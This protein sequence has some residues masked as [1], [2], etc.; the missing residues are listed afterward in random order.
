MEKNSTIDAASKARRFLRAVHPE[1]KYI[2]VSRQD[3]DTKSWWNESLDPRDKDAI[4]S[5]VA[6]A[7]TLNIFVTPA[8]MDGTGG[9]E[10]ENVVGS[11]VAWVDIDPPK[12]R[13]DKDGNPLPQYKQELAEHLEWLEGTALPKLEELGAWVN[14]SGREGGR[15]AYVKLDRQVSADEVRALNKLL[16]SRYR[17]DK[18]WDPSR[19]LRLPG[20][21]NHKTSKRV[22]REAETKRFK[23]VPEELAEEL[24][25]DKPLSELVEESRSTPLADVGDMEPEPIKWSDY[26]ALRSRAVRKPNGLYEAD[27]SAVEEGEQDE[28]QVKKHS[29]IAGSVKECCRYGLSFAQ[30][31]WVLGNCKFAVAKV[32]ESGN[33]LSHY[34]AWA[35]RNPEAVA[36]REE[37]ETD[38]PGETDEPEEDGEDDEESAPDDDLSE[39][40]E[41][42]LRKIRVREE[43]KRRYKAESLTIDVPPI[44]P[45]DEFLSVED[46]PEEYLVQDFWPVSG[47]ALLAA[48][49]KAG[50]TTMMGNVVRALADGTPFLDK[51]HVRQPSGRV[52]LLDVELSERMARR[53]LRDQGI[54]NP[55]NAAIVSLRGRVSSFD[56]TDADTRAHWADALR[57]LG[58]SVVILDCLGPILS[59]MGIDENGT[60]VRRFLTAFNELLGES[61]ATEGMIVHHM[62]HEQERPRGTSVLRDW[63]DSEWKLVRS[64]DERSPRFLSAYG[65]DVDVRETELIYDHESRNLT[66]GVGSRG[67]AKRDAALADIVGFLRANPGS[68]GNAIETALQGSHAQRVI[69]DALKW[70]AEEGP[71][72]Y[73]RGASN[74]K[75]YSLT[76]GTD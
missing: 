49:Y 40:V 57:H 31:L 56:V 67:D 5:L 71:L 54:K 33:P 14:L 65:R 20:T 74:A 16:A 24:G 52:V 44:T 2:V 12:E 75:L 15:H 26:G 43:A 64:G 60:E 19:V 9:R 55:Q 35:W 4:R 39:E 8:E 37:A 28:P 41:A 50:K 11:F 25:A 58:A 1:S 22:A 34:V 10:D 3:P 53:W 68:S 13:K 63:P 29:L 45:L 27:L 73:D 70:G 36:I 17:G 61:G 62:G 47:N 30:T 48:Q 66:V 59:M 18:C 42:E 51:Y 46:E 76:R 38:E 21:I 6:E 32:E 72:K 23:W 7:E 69:R